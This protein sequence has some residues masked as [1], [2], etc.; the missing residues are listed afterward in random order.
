MGVY[1]IKHVG[2]TSDQH[3]GHTMAQTDDM[4]DQ[5]SVLAGKASKQHESQ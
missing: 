1:T 4:Y 3:V 2:Q 5:I